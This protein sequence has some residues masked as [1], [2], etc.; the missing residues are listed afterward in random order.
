MSAP[1]IISWSG[2]KDSALTLQRVWNDPRFTPVGLLT[3]VAP[4][5]RI[6]VH[7][8]R[9]ELLDA[10]AAAI[11]LPLTTMRLPT[12]ASND[13]Y[14]A[15]F[16]EALE[17]IQSNRPE[18][19][20]IAFGDLF[21]ADVRAWRETL[22]A[23]AGWTPVFPLWGEP[24]EGL[25]RAFIADGFA[26]TLV[27]V[28]TTQLDAAFAGRAFDEVLLRDL[29]PAVDPCGERGEF[30]TFVTDGPGFS[31]PVMVRRGTRALRDE[32]FALQDLLPVG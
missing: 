6:G 17:R 30:H 8:V 32:R 7:A 12:E 27:A 16:R 14:G 5:D 1:V 29:P 10:Q 2:G 20:H 31:T 3:T 22:V 24:T 25:A 26:A 15:A 18:V 28:D 21:L 23:E 19:R 13:V 11:G 4:D 9:R